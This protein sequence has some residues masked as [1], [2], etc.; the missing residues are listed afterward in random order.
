MSQLLLSTTSLQIAT[1]LGGGIA[2]TKA[3]ASALKLPRGNNYG[4]VCRVVGSFGSSIVGRDR[5]IVAGQFPQGYQR[6]D[7][8][9][10]SKANLGKAGG[11]DTELLYCC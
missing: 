10:G 1:L 6:M 8:D 4:S 5:F 3:I 11:T 2:G 9:R 7:R